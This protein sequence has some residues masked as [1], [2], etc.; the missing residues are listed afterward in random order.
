MSQDKQAFM[1]DLI[2]S[3]NKFF[4]WV[5]NLVE[6]KEREQAEMVGRF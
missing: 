1:Q 2:A 6:R 3:M 5:T 4:S